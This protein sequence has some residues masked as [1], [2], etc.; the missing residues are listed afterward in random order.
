MC[1]CGGVGGGRVGGSCAMGCYIESSAAHICAACSSARNYLYVFKDI[2]N[3]H[4]FL[5][6]QLPVSNTELA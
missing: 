6:F 4:V 5:F 1:V 2:V 3:A